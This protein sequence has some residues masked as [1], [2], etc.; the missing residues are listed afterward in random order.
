MQVKPVLLGQA[1][2]LKGDGRAFSGPSG[3]TV[4]R[5][6]GVNTRD[7]LERLF[8]LENLL[9][10]PLPLNPDPKCRSSQLTRPLAREGVANLKGRMRVRL[11][12]KLTPQGYNDWIDSGNPVVVVAL[13]TKVWRGF[14]LPHKSPWFDLQL[15]DGGEFAVVK[16][17]HPSGLNH[18]LN[19]QRFAREVATRLRRIALGHLD[20]PHP[21]DPNHTLNRL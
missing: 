1:P 9:L 11:R 13:G 4:M 17:P 16:F 6:L 14:D 19:D 18:E 10:K 20:S 3:N 2:S 7:E 12:L 5:W 8:Y 15:V 21:T